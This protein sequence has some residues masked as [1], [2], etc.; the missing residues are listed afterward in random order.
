M[1]P[2]TWIKGRIADCAREQRIET[3]LHNVKWAERNGSLYFARLQAAD[4]QKEINQRS[5][6]QRARMAKKSAKKVTHG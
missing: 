6:A 4:L 3:H 2:I 1:N 5:P